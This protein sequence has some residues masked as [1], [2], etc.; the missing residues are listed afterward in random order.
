M[1]QFVRKIEVERGWF[2]RA[3]ALPRGR[4]GFAIAVF[5]KGRYEG[6]LGPGESLSMGERV[7][8]DFEFFEVDLQLQTQR[9]A[10]SLGSKD[11]AFF[12]Q[13]EVTIGFAVANAE[14]IVSKVQQPVEMLVDRVVERATEAA[15]KYGV[16]DYRQAQKAIKDAILAGDYR[17]TG[18]RLETVTATITLDKKERELV[19]QLAAL[20]HRQEIG[21]RQAEVDAKI[22]KAQAK[23]FKDVLKSGELGML[24]YELQKDSNAISRIRKELLERRNEDYRRKLDV[25]LKFLDADVIEPA[26]LNLDTEL[27]P[28]LRSLVH[29]TLSMD[30]LVQSL[31]ASDSKHPALLPDDLS[32]SPEDFGNAD[33]D[34]E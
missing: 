12:F 15:A 32:G 19:D 25:L 27:I 7:F 33:P 34:K 11:E 6:V 13:T 22:S 26:Q 20:D 4:A 16:R 18:L 23:Q 9:I 8:G 29:D 24:V 30:N 31:P 5:H 3:K 2:G 21:L 1:N 17:I 28:I 14:A 10:L